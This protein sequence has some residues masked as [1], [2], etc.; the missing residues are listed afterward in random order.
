[1][2][3][4]RRLTANCPE[5]WYSDRFLEENERRQMSVDVGQR[6]NKNMAWRGPITRDQRYDSIW[7]D[8]AQKAWITAGILIAGSLRIETFEGSR[9]DL[10]GQLL[11]GY[12]IEKVIRGEAMLL[13]D[14]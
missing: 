3:K 12:S 4:L 6:R 5:H 8:P 2:Q 1:V 9:P 11:I 14:I 10:A 7:S 13:R